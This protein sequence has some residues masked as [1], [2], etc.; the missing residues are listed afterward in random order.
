MVNKTDTGNS[1]QAVQCFKNLT[2]N[3]FQNLYEPL[4][5][6][7]YVNTICLIYIYNMFLVKPSK[8][9]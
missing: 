8:K 6:T 9:N 2:H 5:K 7:L 1:L 4:R 3:G